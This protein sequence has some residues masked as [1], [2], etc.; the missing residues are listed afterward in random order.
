MTKAVN[1]TCP[2]SGDPVSPDSLAHYRGQ[3]VGFCN[4]GCRDKFEKATLAFDKAIAARDAF[5]R[6]APVE[7]SPYRPRQVTALGNWCVGDMRL[8]LTCMT[9][10]EEAVISEGMIEAARRF[11]EEILP[12]K[13]AIEGTDHHA[14]FVVLHEGEMGTWLL[15]HW[16]AHGDIQLSFLAMALPGTEEFHLQTD[17]HFHACVWEQ[18]VI[19]FERDAWVTHVMK[20]GGR[21]DDYLEARLAD[22]LY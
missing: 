3:T 7:V 4:P 19:G 15:V 6:G 5:P 9:A 16:W 22:G 1:E 21:I 2:W 13:R 20:E 14:G 18:V 10:E 12:Q 11:T 8:K 17:R